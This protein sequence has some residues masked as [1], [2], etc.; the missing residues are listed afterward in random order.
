M[1]TWGINEYMDEKTSKK[2][3][4]MALQFPNPE[5]NNEQ[6]SAFLN[7]L[8]DF[9]SKI[10]ADAITNC[11]DWLGKPKISDEVIDA[12]WTPMLK[13]PKIKESGEFDYSRPPTLKIKIPFWEGEFKNIE[14]YND[15]GD[16]LFPSEDSPLIEDL[17]SKGSNI[18]TLIQCGGLWF[19]NGKFGV[20]W[21]LFQAVVKPRESFKGKC[22][23]NISSDD[24]EKMTNTISENVAKQ[25][26]DS[27]EDEEEEN[28]DQKDDS[29]L[30]SEPVPP[31]PPPK[32]D[33]EP[34]LNNEPEPESKS[35]GDKKVTKKVVKKKKSSD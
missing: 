26:E 29:L 33:I 23:I 11:R 31:P 27:D 5:Y 9:E 28:D 14:L 4:D 10:K 35:D 3:Y 12:L 21:K 7:A 16:Q 20:T 19:A 15:S 8:Q 2:T 30:V 18:A 13:Y 6:I 24:R 32:S 1:L 25:V 22:H 34:E 17:I